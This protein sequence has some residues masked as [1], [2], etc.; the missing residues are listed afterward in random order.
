MQRN[1]RSRPVCAQVWK[2][3]KGVLRNVKPTS[4][5]SLSS[6]GIQNKDLSAADRTK[7]V[8]DYL[9]DTG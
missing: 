6:L 2:S 1:G 7:P 4:A 8:L 9:C 3:E 5:C